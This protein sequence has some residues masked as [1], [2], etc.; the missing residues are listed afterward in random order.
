MN[1]ILKLKHVLK[2][3]SGIGDYNRQ[4]IECS[5]P[6]KVKD[7]AVVQNLVKSI[8][9]WESN[10]WD[11]DAKPLR[12]LESGLLASDRLQ[13]DLEVAKQEGEHQV[14]QFLTERLQSNTK[15]IHA[16]LKLNKRCNFYK[17]P[18]EESNL[19]A[20]KTDRMEN[21]AMAWL[22][23]IAEGKSS[24][25]EHVMEFRLTDVCLSL[26]DINGSM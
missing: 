15:P 1:K 7:E 22:I 10:P 24:K 18:S 14:T 8:E 2:D 9:L 11:A 13:K 6:R 3:I 23:T 25:L 20:W 21:K 19:N 5:T 17:P 26:F 12:S 16:P 4:H